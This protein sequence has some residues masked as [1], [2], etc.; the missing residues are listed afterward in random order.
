MDEALTYVLHFGH[1]PT[2]TS[3]LTA[4]STFLQNTEYLSILLPWFAT[5]HMVTTKKSMR[6]PILS[7][8]DKFCYDGKGEY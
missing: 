3:I 6:N 8:L 5:P 2:K 4:C 7:E 1:G